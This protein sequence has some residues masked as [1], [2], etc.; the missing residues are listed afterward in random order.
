MTGVDVNPEMLRVARQFVPSGTFQEGVAE[1]LPFPDRSFDLLFMGLLLHETDDIAA[2]L[3]EAHRV[4]R[5][6]LVVLE[7]RDEEQEFGPPLD[8]RLDANVV[9][10]LAERAGFRKIETIPLTYLVL[11]RMDR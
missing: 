7:W 5:R 11:Y 8:H 2:A 4:T 6:R 9:I 10:T 1:A 3:A